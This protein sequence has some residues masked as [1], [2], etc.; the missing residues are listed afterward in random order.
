MVIHR[1]PESFALRP[2]DVQC[3]VQA[4]DDALSSLGLARRD[5]PQTRRV[6]RKIIEIA[7]SGERDPIKICRRAIERLG[8]SRPRCKTDGPLS[9]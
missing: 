3:L 7:Q 6:A 8:T 1:R 2:E 9:R 4:Y 5:D